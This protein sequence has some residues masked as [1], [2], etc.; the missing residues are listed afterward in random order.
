MSFG[1]LGMF[2]EGAWQEFRSFILQ[3][4][5]DALKRVNTIN[6][7]IKR[8]GHIRVVYG[9]SNPDDPNSSPTE[10]RIGIQVQEG[11]ALAKLLQAY[12]AQGGNPFDISMFMYPDTS[13]DTGQTREDLSQWGDVNATE[14]I[15]GNENLR[16]NRGQTEVFRDEYP[17][18]GMTWPEDSDPGSGGI[19]TGGWLPIWRYPPRKVGTNQSFATDISETG[20]AIDRARDWVSQEIK[21][22]RNDLEARIIKLCDLKEQLTNERDVTLPQAI[23]GTIDGLD[24]IGAET[25][26]I[27]FIVDEIDAIYY[28]VTL[29]D[30]SPDFNQPRDYDPQ[31]EYPVLLCD[32]PTNEEDWT[33]IG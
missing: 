25:H 24:F 13:V 18:G 2:R 19:Y 22:L 6:A 12:I 32:A 28:P 3:Q 10:E 15:S 11:T 1:W 4:R 30:G 33:A 27:A 7:E 17:Y 8:I 21:T 14:F 16:V 20:F 26:H 31:A 29:E 9:R 5:R 23:G